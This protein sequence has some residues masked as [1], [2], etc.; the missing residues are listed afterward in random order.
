MPDHI[1]F[2]VWLGP[3]EENVASPTLGNIVG[4]LKSRTA[5]EWSRHLR[6]KGNPSPRKL[7]HDRYYEH[8]IRDDDDLQVK[9]QYIQN[10]PLVAQ[11]KKE[12]HH[13]P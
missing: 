11:L 13:H 8:I 7:W 2:I 9:R 3:K 6:Y 1:H 12:H 5:V 4:V 10:N